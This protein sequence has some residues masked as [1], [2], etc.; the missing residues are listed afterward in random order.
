MPYV[1]N[2]A[3]ILP[4]GSRAWHSCPDLTIEADHMKRTMVY[5]IA[6]LQS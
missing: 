3:Y 2:R 4:R 6:T 5:M 1:P